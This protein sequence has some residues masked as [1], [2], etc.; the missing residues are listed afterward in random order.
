LISSLVVSVL[1]AQSPQAFKYQALARDQ[2]G[3]ILPNWNIALRICIVEQ[4]QDG[5]TVYIETQQVRSNLYGMITLA[6]GEGSVTKGSF[7]TISWGENK[8]FIKME[9]D[10]DGGSNYKEMGT[11]QLYAVPYALYAEQA[12]NLMNNEPEQPAP[13]SKSPVS[14]PRRIGPTR[15]G[16]TPNSKFPA[17]TNSYINVNVG[18]VGI[19]TTDPTEKLDVVGNARIDSVYTN[20][21]AGNSPL[22]FQTDGRTRMLIE[23]GRAGVGVNTTSVDS[24]AV[25]ELK[26]T[27]KGFLPPRMITTERDNIVNPAQGL[28]IFNQDC[29][30]INFFDGVKWVEYGADPNNLAFECGDYIVDERDGTTYL[31]LQVGNQ[32][33]MA[34]NLNVGKKIDGDEEQTDDDVIE[35]YCYG[36]I[37]SNCT[38]LG[39]L[40]QWDEMMQ[41]DTNKLN[42]GICPEDWRLPTATE[43]DTLVNF[44]DGESLAGDALKEDGTTGFEA[45]L[46][47][48]RIAGGTFLDKAEKGMFW[49]AEQ[50]SASSAK[51]SYLSTGDAGFYQDEILKTHGLAI[52]CVKGLPTRVDTGVIVIDT[53]V[54]ELLSDSVQLAAGLYK[55]IILQTDQQEEIVPGVIIVGDIVTGGYLRRVTDTLFIGNQMDLQTE[56]ATMEDIWESSEFADTTR[57][58]G[59]DVRGDTKWTQTTIDYLAK[60]V[61]L[62]MTRGGFRYDFDNVILYEEGGV[63]LSL[64]DGHVILDP[65]FKFSV[66]VKRRKLK[67][68]GVKANDA[69]FEISC[70]IALDAAGGVELEYEKKLATTTKKVRFMV[71]WIPVWIK[72]KT[73]LMLYNTVTLDASFNATTGYT[74]TTNLDVGIEYYKGNW[75][76]TWNPSNEDSIHPLVTSGDANF[77][78]R[79]SIVPKISFLVYGKAGPWFNLEFYEQFEE[80]IEFPPGFPEMLWDMELGLGLDANLGAKIKVF[81]KVASY[82]IPIEGPYRAIWTAPAVLHDISG[83][84]QQADAGEE[85]PNPIKVRVTDNLNN[86]LPIVPVLFE[87]TSGG[88]SVADTILLTDAD[89]YAETTWTMGPDEGQNTVTVSV[90]NSEFEDIDD[91]PFEFTAS[92]GGSGTCFGIETVDYGGQTYNTV[93]IGEQCWLKENLNIGSRVDGADDQTDDEEIEKYCMDDLESN[94]D[95]YG[96]LYQWDEAMDYNTNEGAQ[97][98]C[99]DGWHIPSNNEFT[100]LSTYLGGENI[101]GGKMKTTGTTGAGTGLWF[102]PNTGATNESGFTGLPGGRRRSDISSFGNLHASA[103][104]WSSSAYDDSRIWNRILFLDGENI[105]G[106]VSTKIDGKSIRCLKNDQ[107]VLDIIKNGVFQDENQDGFADAGETISYTF[108][109]ENI[110]NVTLTNVTVT[111]PL[112]PVSGGPTTIDVDETDGSTFTASYTITQADCDARQVVNTAT[113]D[114]DESDPDSDEETTILP[115]APSSSCPEVLIDPRDSK[116]YLTID[117]DGQCWM[118]ENLNVGDR[119]DGVDDQTDDEEIDKYCWDDQESNCDIYGGLYMWDEA[120]DYSTI[121]GA[122]G[123]CPDNWHLPTDEEWTTLSNILG[124]EAVAGGKMKSTGNLTDGTG[125]WIHP[126]IGATNESGFSGLPGGVRDY[127]PESFSLLGE[128]AWFWSSS[129]NDPYAVSALQLK[130]YVTNLEMHLDGPTFYGFSVRCILDE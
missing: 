28:I 14:K 7:K 37:P 120:M 89:G 22:H 56:Q 35:K 45:L 74:N 21:V 13:V 88:G 2:E 90:F 125:L 66:K 57:V 102:S 18:N 95:I 9:M 81:G 127:S 70:D 58:G 67:K 83:H 25:L 99:P 103:E 4:Q 12:G 93:L 60:G 80:N 64:P 8:Y 71:G 61:S 130:N 94:C 48:Q 113:A 24:S 3:H 16:S 55:Y 109:V 52:R 111:D 6:I 105:F 42:S 5:Q 96:G 124:G 123:I 106:T 47:G 84:D 26:S 44:L 76:K 110:G 82:G 115:H 112:V 117:I 41:Y 87:P 10:I 129:L 107:A 114:S 122:Q 86:G 98:I 73:D 63:T 20:A 118:A 23:E 59:D 92:A 32:C 33:W 40:Y 50:L 97:G 49:S 85:L 77:T 100:T 121:E 31:T 101:A 29:E 39:G 104:F 72:I 30:C 128:H 1:L 62:N 36:N 51:Y 46:G 27:A 17:D 75:K 69:L 119:I 43:W 11:T 15:T 78:Q 19:G 108:S 126:N 54:Y 38:K 65:N 34:E 68:L 53:L 79:L 91:S 116:A